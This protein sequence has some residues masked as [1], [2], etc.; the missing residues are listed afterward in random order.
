MF[1]AAA[2][3]KEQES[4]NKS[5]N[6]CEGEE[7]PQAGRQGERNGGEQRRGRPGE[8]RQSPGRLGCQCTI[9]II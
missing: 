8:E 4:I 7:E 2:D 3:L 6:V 5:N 1:I 9:E